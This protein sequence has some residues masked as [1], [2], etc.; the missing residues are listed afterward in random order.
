MPRVLGGQG[1]ALG[2]LQPDTCQDLRFLPLPRR[3]DFGSQESARKTV[4]TVGLREPGGGPPRVASHVLH[5]T[6]CTYVLNDPAAL[7]TATGAALPT[8]VE[9]SRTSPLPSP[10]TSLAKQKCRF[11]ALAPRHPEGLLGETPGPLGSLTL[12]V[13]PGEP[14]P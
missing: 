13:T 5:V 14:P 3:A 11:S 2:R 7:D 4:L 6:V 9:D 8:P 1:P 10:S 12:S